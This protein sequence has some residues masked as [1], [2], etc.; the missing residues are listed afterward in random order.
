MKKT[1]LIYLGPAGSYTEIA[2]ESILAELGITDFN[3][4]IKNSILSVIKSMN[5]SDG[6]I[7]VMPVENSIEGIVRET[8]DNLVKTTTRVMITGEIIIP[9][10]HCLISRAKTIDEIDKIVS[11]SQALAQCRH[12]LEKT[13]PNSEKIP[14]NSTS[15]AVKQLKDLP[16]NYAAVGSCKAAEIYG[17]NILFSNINDE[18]NNITRFVSL[19]SEIPSMT[20]NDKT[21]IA[22]STT[23]KPGALFEV[24]SIL[25]EK[26]INLSYLESRPSKKVFGDYTFFMDFEGHI[27]DENIRQAVGK[28]MPYVNFYRFLGSY[29]K[30]KIAQ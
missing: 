11:I 10:S 12:F 22:F 27:E 3:R 18:K 8:V 6:N 16:A 13:F 26:N 30:G 15:E 2:A 28:I 14:T 9:I 24:L 1:N 17:F 20:G 25:K 29:A 5:N 19:G 21:S 7:G 4:G 23:N